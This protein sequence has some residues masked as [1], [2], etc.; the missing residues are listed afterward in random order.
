M[1]Q[2]FLAL[3]FLAIVLPQQAAAHATPVHYNPDAS[4]VLEAVPAHIHIRFSER[5]E[6]AASSIIVFGPDGSRVGEKLI[7]DPADAHVA[8]VD[9]QRTATGSY[10]VSWNIMSAD[11]GHSSKGAY[12]FSVGKA[13]QTTQ[14]SPTVVT[15]RMSIIEVLSIWLELFGLSLLTGLFVIALL[16]DVTSSGERFLRIGIIASML[17]MLGTLI[18]GIFQVVHLPE[19][20]GVLS[21]LSTVSG[22][23]L[24]LRFQIGRAHV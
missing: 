3:G 4:A 10:A 15:Y 14:E 6:P 18:F 7:V 8:M 16:I 24:K 19:T 5:I 12:S 9:V 2:I 13:D 21:T 1:R 11:D 20:S 23:L 22:R 17:V